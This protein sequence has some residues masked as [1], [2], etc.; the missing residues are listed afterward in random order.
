MGRNRGRS[1]QTPEDRLQLLVSLQ[2]ISDQDVICGRNERPGSHEGNRKYHALIHAYRVD[3]QN[4]SIPKRDKGKMVRAIYQE[5]TKRG[6][7]FLKRDRNSGDL[8]PAEYHEVRDKIS[9]ALRS[10]RAPRPKNIPQKRV[11][12]Y[13]PFTPK[14]EIAFQKLLRAQQAFLGNKS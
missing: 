14:E 8:I 6:G 5:I 2:D 13:K 1:K 10:A 3:Y 7:R 11:Y 12:V 4:R 9:H